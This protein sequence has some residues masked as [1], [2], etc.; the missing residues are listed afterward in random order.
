LM[1]HND[2]LRDVRWWLWI[3]VK[4]K[5]V[6]ALIEDYKVAVKTWLGVSAHTW[7]GDDV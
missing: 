7:R 1:H 5:S 6:Q 2:E 3:H 4:A